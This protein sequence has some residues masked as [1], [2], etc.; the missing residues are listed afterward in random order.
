MAER[1]ADALLQ[2]NHTEAT[3]LMRREIVYLGGGILGLL[4]MAT[5]GV[6]LLRKV[7]SSTS[8][9]RL[10]NRLGWRIGVCV[11]LLVAGVL[12][13]RQHSVQVSTPPW[14]DPWHDARWAIK[15]VVSQA[16]SRVKAGD[17]RRALELMEIL[18]RGRVRQR[19]NISSSELGL[20]PATAALYDQAVEGVWEEYYGPI[21][22]TVEESGW[23][24]LE[25]EAGDSIVVKRWKGEARACVSQIRHRIRQGQFLAEEFSS[26]RDRIEALISASAFELYKMSEIARKIDSLKQRFNGVAD[27]EAIRAEFESHLQAARKALDAGEVQAASKETF[28]AEG[29]LQKPTEKQK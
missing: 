5:P 20:D 17:R 11:I 24:T 28:S 14:P 10:S 27:R 23:K 13:A 12:V 2:Q 22:K 19:M 18:V 21:R 8:A 16:N 26:L 15:N 3:A 25:E 1:P 4:A 6:F 7:L 29:L 9:R